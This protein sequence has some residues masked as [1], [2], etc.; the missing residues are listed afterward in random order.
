MITDLKQR[1]VD[2]EAN[3]GARSAP[4]Y[5]VITNPY[6]EF[7][8]KDHV[9]CHAYWMIAFGAGENTPPRVAA[10]GREYDRSCA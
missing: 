10:A 4:M 6:I 7:V 3:G 9:R 8:D 5:H 1:Q 2:R